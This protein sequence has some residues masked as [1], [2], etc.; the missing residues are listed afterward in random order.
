MIIGI[1]GL[2]EL[3]FAF[4]FSRVRSELVHNDKG[5]IFLSKR[6]VKS[7]A[8]KFFRFQENNLFAFMLCKAKNP[9]SF[10]VFLENLQRANLLTVLSDL[11]N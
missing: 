6:F 8:C 3:A 10:V 2:V 4:L 9:N 11:Y 1:L 7:Q 5:N